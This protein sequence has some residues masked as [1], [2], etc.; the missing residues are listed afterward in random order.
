MWKQAI[1]KF[2]DGING[3]VDFIEREKTIRAVKKDPGVYL[4]LTDK[5]KHDM[6]IIM[7]TLIIKP[8]LFIQ[9]DADIKKD[10]KMIKKVIKENPKIVYFLGDSVCRSIAKRDGSLYEYM[11]N[12]TKKIKR[13]AEDALANYAGAIKHVPDQYLKDEYFL[14]NVCKQNNEI[15]KH[16]K[17]DVLSQSKD[18]VIMGIDCQ[19]FKS[20]IQ[21][22][23]NFRNDPDVMEKLSAVKESFKHT[24]KPI[25]KNKTTVE[26]PVVESF[27]QKSEQFKK[28]SQASDNK[29]KTKF[30]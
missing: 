6:D 3:V 12:D 29:V 25:S 30:G 4:T 22:P 17:D 8:E 7:A 10:T 13:I 23:V 1:Q 9:M 15:F 24:D 5:Y 2:K 27:N 19:A 16:I 18:L 21:I 11:R 20:E 28:Q 26:K 14:I